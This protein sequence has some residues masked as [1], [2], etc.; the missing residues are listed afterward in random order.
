[1]AIAQYEPNPAASIDGST[2]G[3]R[4]TI[5]PRMPAVR[6]SIS[7]L[8]RL[9]SSARPLSAA[10][11]A[12][13]LGMP[14]SSI[15]QMLQVLI[16]EGL[17]AHVPENRTYT[18]GVGVFELG[19]AY[20]RHEPLEHLARPLLVKLAQKLGETAQLGILQGNETLYLLKEQ[21]L[22]FTA[23]V[24][25]VGVRLPAHLTASGRSMLCSLPA[26]Q[27]MAFFAGPASFPMLT[28]S[29]PS[30]IRTLMQVLRE[31]EQRGWSFEEGNVSDGI[32]CVAAAVR[33]KS[34]RPVA[35]IVTSFTT[36]RHVGEYEAIAEEI[37]HA[38]NELTHRLGGSVALSLRA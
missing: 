10:A 8:R 31:D 1:M 26:R 35:S 12:R 15:Y 7:L 30:S 38:A 21:P 17:V 29:G 28:G 14:R 5:G 9:A 20:L 33:D 6:N 23:L 19:S 13:A 11:L 25:E 36:A 16:D 32:S 2:P 3:P 34:G 22:H 18:L 37:V 4:P 24:T 27:V